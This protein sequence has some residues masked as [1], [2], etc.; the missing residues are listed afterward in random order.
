VPETVG[1]K[2]KRRMPTATAQTIAAMIATSFTRW[3][4]SSCFFVSFFLLLPPFALFAC[5][6][7]VFLEEALLAVP[8]L[9]ED[10]F[11]PFVT[12]F[13]ACWAVPFFTAIASPSILLCVTP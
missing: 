12:C 9:L 5:L 7:A 10:A 4:T 11:L 13:A 6:A 2:T 3:R 8:E 1:S